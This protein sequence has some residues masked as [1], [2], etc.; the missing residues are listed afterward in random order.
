MAA[1]LV[2]EQDGGSDYG[3]EFTPDEEEILNGLLQEAPFEPD[4]PITDPEHQIKETEDALTQGVKVRRLGHD[5]HSFSS[6]FTGDTRSTTQ[7]HSDGII[8]TNGMPC[9][10]FDNLAD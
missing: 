5:E 3:S 1:S 10:A 6:P 7:V 8:T 4:N 2:D 9:V